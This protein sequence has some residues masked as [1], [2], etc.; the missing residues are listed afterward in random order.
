MYDWWGDSSAKDDLHTHT[1]INRLTVMNGYFPT[2]R[3]RRRWGEKRW[4]EKRGEAFFHVMGRKME[5]GLSFVNDSVLDF[6]SQAV[7]GCIESENMNRCHAEAV[8]CNAP[9][10]SSWNRVQRKSTQGLMSSLEQEIYD[11]YGGRRDFRWMSVSACVSLSCFDHKTTTK[12][13]S[14]PLVKKVQMFLR[15]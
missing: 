8:D 4:E 12:Q 5:K 3:R 6:S 15:D 2:E 11:S 9:T 10:P 7:C 13:R 14:R 1:G